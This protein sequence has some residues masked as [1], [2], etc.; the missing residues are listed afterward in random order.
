MVGGGISWRH[1]CVTHFYGI[2]LGS[3]DLIERLVETLTE[4]E[5]RVDE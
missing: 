5:I 2:P 3:F 1:S 4:A